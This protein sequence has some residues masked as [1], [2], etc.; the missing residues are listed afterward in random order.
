MT[1]V[2]KTLTIPSEQEAWLRENFISPSR[3]LQ[4]KIRE[5]MEKKNQEG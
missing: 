4:A 2:R 5:A 3:F 1:C